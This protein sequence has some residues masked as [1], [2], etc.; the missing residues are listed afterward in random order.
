L[1]EAAHRLRERRCGEFQVE[2][3]GEGKELPLLRRMVVAYSLEDLIH[4]HPPM[5]PEEVREK[6]RESH[7]YVLPSDY[8]EGWGAVIN[9]AMD[10]GCC[11]VSSTGPGAAP[12]LIRHGET[13]F[14]FQS[15]NV[16][17]LTSCLAELV[18]FPE[19]CRVIGERA[20]VSVR[21]RWSPEVVADRI[22]ALSEGLLG[23]REM[24]NYSDGPC[25]RD[26]LLQPNDVESNLG[27]SCCNVL[28]P[29]SLRREGIRVE[30][31]GRG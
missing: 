31:T 29:H 14:L 21:S 6:M 26:S 7:I 5:S 24:P 11:V 9:E 4:F 16:E 17:N 30:R 2:I 15:G 25:S 20:Q 27:L 12:W 8:E 13:G 10:A 3:I 23:R 22:I 18:S 28:E 19:S 1:I